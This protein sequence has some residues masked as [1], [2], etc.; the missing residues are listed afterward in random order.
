MDLSRSL[1]F[2]GREAVMTNIRWARIRL[3]FDDD[4]DVE[5][6]RPKAR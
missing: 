6:G 3:K 4:V 1:A 5:D 2:H